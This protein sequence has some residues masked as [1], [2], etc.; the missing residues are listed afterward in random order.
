MTENQEVK[1]RKSQSSE[2]H[3]TNYN[4]GVLVNV[5][6]LTCKFCGARLTLAGDGRFCP[7][8]GKTQ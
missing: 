8:C 7:E 5:G 4:Q 1:S 2:N 6:V 3:K